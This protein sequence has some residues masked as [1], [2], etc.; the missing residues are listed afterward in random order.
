MCTIIQHLFTMP[1]NERQLHNGLLISNNQ[2]SLHSEK[3]HLYQCV[4]YILQIEIWI[5]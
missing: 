1:I 4:F 3:H 2:E 5:Q